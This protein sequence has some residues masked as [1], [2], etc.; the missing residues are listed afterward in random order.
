MVISLHPG[1]L[2]DFRV[3][4]HEQSLHPLLRV[5]AVSS[6]AGLRK[7]HA[8]VVRF[9]SCGYVEGKALLVL[10]VPQGKAELRSERC[11]R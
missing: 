3:H 11:S 4:L 6:K 8:G 2:L 7:M 9:A 5:L 1:R 10:S